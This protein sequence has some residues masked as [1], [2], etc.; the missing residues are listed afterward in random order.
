MKKDLRNFG[1]IWAA[2]LLIIA[3]VPLFKG[4]QARL[5][6]LGVALL[7]VISS[8]S[9][10][11]IYSKTKFYQGWIKFGGVIGKINSKIIIFILFYF[12]FLPVGL[13][14]KILK[15]DLLSKKLDKSR[16]SYFVDRKMQPG[17]MKNQF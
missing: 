9:F 17:D 10:P 11:E 6:A 2:I 12:I 3:L 1:L 13:I 7:F 14:L 5:W 16:A 8:L 4:E 15:K